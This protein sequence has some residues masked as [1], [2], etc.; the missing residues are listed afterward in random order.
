MK[1]NYHHGMCP[2]DQYVPLSIGAEERGFD[3]VTMPESICYPKE[4]TSQY[5]YN[6]DGSRE[7]LESVPFIE[8]LLLSAH[9]AAVTTKLTFTTSVVKLAIRQPAIAAKQLSSL[10]VLSNNR[11]KF[12]VGISP[13]EED[14]EIAQIPWAKRGKR[15]DEMVEIIRGLMGGDYFG[16]KG[17]IF[18]MPEI[19]LCP[20]PSQPV[21]FLIGG[22]SKPAL[23]RAALLG[24][25]WI[26]AG[27]DLATT[28]SYI[29]EINT[30]RKEF[31]RDHLP[32]EMSAM[33]AEAFSAD[34]IRQ[35]E[36]IGVTEV[37]VGFR[38]VYEQEPD[39]KSVAEK[40]AM[41]DWYANEVIAKV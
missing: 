21:P 9:L 31:G 8:P 3:G 27:A 20:V 17:E 40:L 23:K 41:M 28:K 38:N 32:F 5:P 36:D 35:L 16:Y 6:A 1:Y 26:A 29:D 15:M 10:A 39:D 12:G 24:D 30:L 18:D 4:A 14:F 19:K 33:G 34:G 11:F 22:H 2:A 25:G 13:W 37:T 7:F